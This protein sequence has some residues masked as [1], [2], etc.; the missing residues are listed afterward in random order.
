MPETSSLI[1]ENITGDQAMTVTRNML[2]KPIKEVFE[3]KVKMFSGRE[4]SVEWMKNIDNWVRFSGQTLLSTFNMLLTD[5]ARTMFENARC[6]DDKS[7]RAWFKQNF[8][9]TKNAA[10]Y[11]DELSNMMQDAD[12]KFALFHIRIR[13]KVKELSEIMKD[14]ENVIKSLLKTKVNSVALKEKFIFDENQSIDDM[15]KKAKMYEDSQPETQS[16]WQV[17]KSNVRETRV[18]YNEVA[19]GKNDYQQMQ[20]RKPV[21]REYTNDAAKQEVQTRM[22]KYSLKAIAR[23]KL[24]KVEGKS[25]PKL[26]ELKPGMCFCCGDRGHIQKQCPL[27]KKCVICGSASHLFRDCHRLKKKSIVQT[28]CIE[29]ETDASEDIYSDVIDH[30]VNAL[31]G[32]DL[33]ES[34]SFV[35]SN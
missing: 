1:D 9:K 31:N 19:R 16:V 10:N 11:I 7:C 12:E 27:Y 21:Q 17:Q 32:N 34:I 25:V 23:S 14:E 2:P 5:E 35:G 30:E 26:D 3:N 24:C 29:D 4:D 20:Q 33:I 22:P 28:M 15:V 6:K 8:L 13:N 18:P